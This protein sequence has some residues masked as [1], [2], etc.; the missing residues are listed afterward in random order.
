MLKIYVLYFQNRKPLRSFMCP[1]GS[2]S[3]CLSLSVS[4]LS[5]SLSLSLVQNNMICKKFYYITL[6]KAWPVREI[7]LTRGKKK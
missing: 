4:S 3:V 5:L 6:Y 7:L 2:L 1:V